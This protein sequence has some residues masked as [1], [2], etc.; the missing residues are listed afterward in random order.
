MVMLIPVVVLV[1]IFV[2]IVIASAIV[3]IGDD[4]RGAVVRL[5]K[6]LTALGPG[7][8]IRLP[9]VDRVTKVD[10]DASIPGWQGLSDRELEAA[11][12]SF[13]TG[14]AAARAKSATNRSA[15]L[16]KP[17]SRSPESQALAA[18]L[19]KAAGDKLNVDLSNDHMAKDRIAERADSAIEELRSSS[20]SEINLPFLTAD[21]TGPKHF[22]ISLTRSQVEK[23]LGSNLR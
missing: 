6:F 16:P 2:V 18:W 9:F 19:V 10:L 23:V 11:V 3:V 8:H 13:V 22:S 5:G 4:Q 20:S 7:F 12:E 17:S 15:S 1:G 21:A 14:G